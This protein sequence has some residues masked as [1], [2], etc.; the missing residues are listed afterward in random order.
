[1]VTPGQPAQGLWLSS[2]HQTLALGHTVH[3]EC[4]QASLSTGSFSTS[5]QVV[6]LAPRLSSSTPLAF[7]SLEI[8]I[9][10]FKHARDF[11]DILAALWKKKKKNVW[12]RIVTGLKNKKRGQVR[13]DPIFKEKIISGI[14][15]PSLLLCPVLSADHQLQTRSPQHPNP[16]FI[17]ICQFPSTVGISV[18]A[19]RVSRELSKFHQNEHKSPFSHS[20]KLINW[21]TSWNAPWEWQHRWKGSFHEVRGT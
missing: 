20:Q 11:S 2:F 8:A 7:H 4:T 14:Y 18:T 3:P 13:L 17:L 9:D 12:L 16:V 6:G 21:S 19:V 5:S 1:M 10:H 15:G